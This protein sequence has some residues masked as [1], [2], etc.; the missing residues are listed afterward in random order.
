[1]ELDEI[2][3][4][5]KVEHDPLS[6]IFLVD[7]IQAM[8]I[9]AAWQFVSVSWKQKNAKKMPI[10]PHDRWCWVWLGVSVNMEEVAIMAGVPKD[11]A[12]VIYS[13]LQS[14]RIIFPDSSI[15]PQARALIG[16]YIKSKVT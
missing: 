14:A 9:T 12:K 7:N 16:K 3:N 11:K 6:L 15:H 5:Y 13:M 8:K 10:D 1:M 4:Q 2:L